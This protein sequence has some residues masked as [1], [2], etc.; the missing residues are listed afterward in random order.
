MLPGDP[1]LH[2]LAIDSLGDAIAVAWIDEN[3]DPQTLRFAA[4]APGAPALAPVTLAVG[5]GMR[6]VQVRATPGGAFVTWVHGGSLRGRA[7]RC[8]PSA[9]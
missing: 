9:G 3:A 2:G 7:L 1:T 6:D 5:R 8:A 4:P